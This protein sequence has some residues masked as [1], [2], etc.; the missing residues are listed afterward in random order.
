MGHRASA[1]CSPG[2]LHSPQEQGRG[3]REGRGQTLPTWREVRARLPFGS[4]KR[5][6]ITAAQAKACLGLWGRATS[7]AAQRGS[8]RASRRPPLSRC[9]AL[10]GHLALLS[11]LAAPWA[12]PLR[13]GGLC[14][15]LASCPRV[16]RGRS[17]GRRPGPREVAA[18]RALRVAGPRAPAPG[19]LALGLGLRLL[20]R[21]LTPQ[22]PGPP[23]HALGGQGRAAGDAEAPG[24]GGGC[25]RAGAA[26]GAEEP[27]R[28]WRL[29]G[30]LCDLIGLKRS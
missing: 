21:D 25:G 3:A 7:V 18:E 24:C 29:R 1:L 13:A 23:A 2:A 22:L 4:W 27:A 5:R 10:L 20:G 28:R 19:A 15:S 12:A 26:R 8:L 16:L 17:P 30:S 6:H 11:P 14:E 9:S